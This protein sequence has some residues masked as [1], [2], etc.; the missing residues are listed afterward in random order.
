MQPKNEDNERPQKKHGTAIVVAS[1]KEHLFDFLMLFLAVTL[2]FFVDNFREHYEEDQQTK[3]L[4]QGLID[5]LRKDTSDLNFLLLKREEKIRKL[6]SLNRY[7]GDTS[8][9]DNAKALYNYSAYITERFFFERNNATYQQL[10]NAGY[11]SNFPQDIGKALTEYDVL[12]ERELYLQDN[13][14]VIVRD[15]ILPFMQQVFYTEYFNTILE[16]KIITPQPQLH[17]WNNET[18]WLFH[19]YAFEMQD[20]SKILLNYCKT[21]NDK[22]VTLLQMLEKEYSSK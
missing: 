11:L 12:Y 17:Y 18:R 22:A 8:T 16:E 1:L 6:D 10:T 14:R 3:Q 4:A 15:K 19:N 7:L 2:G 13:E 21:L 5:D 9:G 20:Q